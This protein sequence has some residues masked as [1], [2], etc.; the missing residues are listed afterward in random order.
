[1][2]RPRLDHAREVYW[3]TTNDT[4][5]SRKAKT[6]NITYRNAAPAYSLMGSI[7]RPFPSTFLIK[8]KF[9]RTD[10]AVSERIE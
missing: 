8:S 4:K 9:D 2:M 6:V 1:M 3:L 7:S 10:A 5:K